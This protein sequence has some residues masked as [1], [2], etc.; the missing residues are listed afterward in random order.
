MEIRKQSVHFDADQKLLDFIDRKVSK[1][2][3]FFDRIVSAD[4]IL[5]LEKTGQV[6]DKV[7]E[8]KLNVPGNT[9][10]AKETCKSFE[11]AID[12]SAD[13]LRRQLIKYKE[14]MRKHE[15]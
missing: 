10:I 14:K 3:T 11:E 8:I 15:M 1:L 4:I 6:Q 9:L 5:K 13:V 7:A 2:E 12:K